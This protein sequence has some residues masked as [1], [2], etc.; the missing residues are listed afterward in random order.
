M[1]H[2]RYFILNQKVMVVWGILQVACASL[3]VVCGFID[4]VFRMSTTLSETRAPLWAGTMMAIP[5]VL[6]LFAS[7]RKN[8]TLV[9]V[10]IV[11][12]V[13]SYVATVI[14]FVY[15][16]VTLSY[17]E[18][19]DELF[20]PK[21]IT[22]VKFVLSRMVKA[23]NSTMVLSGVGAL[24]FSSLITYVG[25]RSLPICGC[26]DSVTGMEMLVS[27]N[28]PSASGDLVC[29]WHGGDERVLNSPIS[30]MERCPEQEQE[31]SALPPYSRLT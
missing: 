4:A 27:Q 21:H 16:G 25:C 22:E 2:Y 15:A 28:D 3:C 11:S 8:P 14:V 30:F 20:H 17:G 19:D 6:A 18:E 23:A 5:G 13:V 10:M 24:V 12:S 7:Q 9:T 1:E 26:Y 31:L 29:S